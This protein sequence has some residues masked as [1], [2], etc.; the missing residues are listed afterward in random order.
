MKKTK[1]QL[2]KLIK[3]YYPLFSKTSV[4]TDYLFS[5]NMG[6]GNLKEADKI[7]VILGKPNKVLVDAENQ[8]KKQ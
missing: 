7:N 1:L 8:Q 2:E 6:I 5:S 3:F 4:L